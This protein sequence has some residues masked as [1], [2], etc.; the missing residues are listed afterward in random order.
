[1]VKRQVIISDIFDN[2]TNLKHVMLSGCPS[3]H[4]KDP[5]MSQMRVLIAIQKNSISN[6]NEIAK[7]FKISPSAITQLVNELVKKQL[8]VRQVDKNDKRIINLKLTTNGEKI[9]AQMQKEHMDLLTSIFQSL[10]DEDLLVLDN[11]QKK[12]V[13]HLR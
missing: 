1:M 8:L 4:K 2:M 6:L 10:S 5:T 13:G 9:L 7:F 11:L 12:I 3:I